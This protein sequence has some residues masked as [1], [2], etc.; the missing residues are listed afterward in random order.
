VLIANLLVVERVF[1][2]TSVR[3]L[4]RRADKVHDTSN[5][6]LKQ[7]FDQGYRAASVRQFCGPHEHHRHHDKQEAA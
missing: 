1:D 6:C 5:R 7:V 3:F 4:H 2:R